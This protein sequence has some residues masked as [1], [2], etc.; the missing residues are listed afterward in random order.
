MF[1]QQDAEQNHNLNMRNKSFESV[2]KLKCVGTEQIKTVFTKIL[3]PNQTSGTP[4]KIQS[5]TFC[6]PFCY[7]KI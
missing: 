1:H 7:L 5:S 3:R 2:A 4:A 6:L